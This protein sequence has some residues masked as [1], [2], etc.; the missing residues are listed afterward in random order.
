MQMH[1]SLPRVLLAVWATFLALGL[2]IEL[3]WAG[4]TIPDCAGICDA[5]CASHD[6]CEHYNQPD[7]DCHYSCMDGYHDTA[8][9]GG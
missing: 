4:A 8:Y 3:S 9:C 7:C 6:G 1:R 5:E 2:G